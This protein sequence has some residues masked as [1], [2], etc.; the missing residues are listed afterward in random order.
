MDTMDVYI[1][2]SQLGDR[3]EEESTEVYEA[4][5]REWAS[6]NDVFV[7]VVADDTDVSGSV[8]VSER[9]LEELLVRVES[10]ES[11]G[12]VTPYIDRFGRDLIEGAVALKRIVDAGGKLIAVRDG[13]D[14]TS[15]GSELVFNLRMAIAQDY[16]KRSRE[17]FQS[18]TDR[19][20][21]QGIWIPPRVPFGYVRNGDRRLEVVPD[22]AEV[23]RE[24]YRRRAAGATFSNLQE[25]MNS[26]HKELLAAQRERTRRK[27][28]KQKHRPDISRGGVRSI[29]SNRSYL[30]EMRVASPG[31]KGQSRVVKNHISPLITESEWQAAQIKN[32]FS[33]RNGQSKAAKLRG[34]VW[35]AGCERRCKV[36]AGRRK[37]GTGTKALGYVC[38]GD[39]CGNRAA[40]TATMLE[41]IVGEKLTQ[42][43]MNREPHIAAVIEGDTRYQDALAEVEV[44]QANFD[45]FRDSVEIQQTLGIDGYASGLKAR[46]EALAS[47]RR[48]MSEV[49]PASETGGG[50]TVEFG[51]PEEVGT[52]MEADRF[53]RF[54]DRVV[55]RSANKSKWTDPEDRVDVYW[56][57]AA[58]PV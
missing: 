52:A 50:G 3:E 53:A 17:N 35:C 51:S 23:V 54:V 25:W 14:S 5:C 15:P 26:E 42:A 30:G 12:V 56:K 4:W 34:L 2:V 8:A 24:L 7:G 47:A 11:A 33:P 28:K 32:D 41:E 22:E 38:T 31:K 1:R 46:K 9:R 16:L 29:L 58:E 18:G 43:A 21:R 36:N 13:F 44:A 45:E 19:A 55:L 39:G 57:G 40:M 6:K 10:G 27:G 49:R 20:V 48:H 37:G